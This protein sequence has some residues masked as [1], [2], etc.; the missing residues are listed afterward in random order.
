MIQTQAEIFTA[1]DAVNAGLIDAIKNGETRLECH[2]EINKGELIF[3]QRTFTFTDKNGNLRNGK[4]KDD[5]ELIAFVMIFYPDDED[6]T[7]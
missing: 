1:I 6:E 5:S 4:F 3:D 2:V 7:V